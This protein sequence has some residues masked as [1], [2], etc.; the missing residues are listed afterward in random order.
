MPL[1][2]VHAGAVALL[3]ERAEG[4]GEERGD[5]GKAAQ[6][7]PR[8]L[9]EL[10]G[11]HEANA[12]EAEAETAPLARRDPFPQEDPGQRGGQQRLD[13]D[14][15]R[16]NASLHPQG[17]RHEDTTQVDRMNQQSRHRVVRHLTPALGPGCT[18]SERQQEQQA[19]DE[20]IAQRQEGQRLGMGKAQSRAD[21][22]GAPEHHEK[23][24][25]TDLL[26]QF[27][28]ARP[29]GAEGGSSCHL[30]SCG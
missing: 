8:A 9:P 14:D 20:G 5:A 23:S 25:N 24:R 1:A 10:V 19:D 21:E 29:S 30:S 4:D 13:A 28:P 12:E 7:A 6:R 11:E 2:Q 16:R 27:V 17:D 22:A 15:E 3:V 18:R 26:K